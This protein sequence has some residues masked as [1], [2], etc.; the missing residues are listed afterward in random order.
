MAAKI[1]Y[2]PLGTLE[3]SGISYSTPND[4][5]EITF[6]IPAQKQLVQV[7]LNVVDKTTSLREVCELHSTQD[8]YGKACYRMPATQDVRFINASAEVS[9]TL[10]YP[11]S[12]TYTESKSVS[13]PLT[14]Q[15]YALN[16]QTA[17]CAELCSSAKGY[18]E[19][20]I[21]ALQEVIQKGENDE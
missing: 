11:E 18:Y 7:F 4:I 3:M 1:T 9:L 12:K 5:G 17:L 13:I 14:T 2:T 15:H 8:N 6:Y 10:Y 16:R 20:I 19:A 21:K